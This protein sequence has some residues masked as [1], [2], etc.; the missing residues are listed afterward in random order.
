VSTNISP[1]PCRRARNADRGSIVLPAVILSVLLVA[2]LTAF[3]VVGI[4]ADTDDPTAFDTAGAGFYGTPLTPLPEAGVDP[5]IGEPVPTIEG[6]GPDGEPVTV[7]ADGR[8]T[9]VLFLAHW[10]PHCRAEVPEVAEWLEDGN[11]PED[12]DLVAVSTSVDPGRPNY[13]PSAWLAREGWPAP[14]VADATEA[15][16]NA[17]G[18]TSFPFWAVIDADG[19]LVG[20]MAGRLTS[21]ELEDVL[22]T[23]RSA[24]R[25]SDGGADGGTE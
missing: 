20:R 19:N 9:V 14:V 11:Q 4:D 10:C 7:P 25:S 5:A 24:G 6:E 23:A 1:R 22:D 15:A 17:Y 12:V 8:P 16:A 3:I 21:E 2:G 13:P 18:L